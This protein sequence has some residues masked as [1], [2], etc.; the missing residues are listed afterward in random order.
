MGVGAQPAQFALELFPDYHLGLAAKARGRIAAGDLAGAVA[1]YQRSLDR[2]PLPDT[3]I[4]LGDLYM[5]LG[6]EDAA[7]KQY[8]LVEF[9]ERSAAGGANLYSRQLALFWANHDWKLPEALD[10]AFRD[11]HARSDIYT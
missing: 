10:I 2:V 3:A 1:F 4:A 8:E 7:A 6:R 5:K 9:I 11:G